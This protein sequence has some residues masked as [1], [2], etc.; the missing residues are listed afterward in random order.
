MV[1]EGN[2]HYIERHPPSKTPS[3][4]ATILIYLLSSLLLVILGSLFQ[5]LHLLSGLV[6]SEL[7]FVVAP[8]L[9]FTLH[10]RYHVARTFHLHPITS[11]TAIITIITTVTA[12]VLIGIL[13]VLQEIILPRSEDYQQIWETIL[14]QFHQ[15]PLV[16]TLLLVSLLPGL[17]EEF[18]FR[19]FLLHGVRKKCSDTWAIL[20]VGLLFGAFHLDPYRFFPVTLLGILFGYMVVRTGSLFTGMIAH[21]T[22]NAIAVLISYAVKSAQESG[23][24]L[25]APPSQDVMTLEALLTVIPVFIIALLGFLAGIRALPHNGLP[26]STDEAPAGDVREYSAHDDVNHATPPEH[27]GEAPQDDV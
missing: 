6:I 1:N 3:F 17:C 23:L 8:A 7:A 13:S 24:P 11:K 27:E 9:F 18:L 16:L 14:Q 10:G 25:T 4:K 26:S 19:G 15:I 22:N 2:Q 12:F 5:S 20:V 21:G